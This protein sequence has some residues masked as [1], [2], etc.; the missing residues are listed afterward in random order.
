ME[1]VMGFWAS[2]DRWLTQREYNSYKRFIRRRYME[3][4]GAP[5]PRTDEQLLEYFKQG[6]APIDVM[7]DA[8]GTALTLREMDHQRSVKMAGDKL[9]A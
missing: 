2:V 7:L 1:S 6:L 5:L 3:V 4:Y 9:R 8:A